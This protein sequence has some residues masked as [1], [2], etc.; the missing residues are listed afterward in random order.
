M[1]KLKSVQSYPGLQHLVSDLKVMKLSWD[2]VMKLSLVWIKTWI[3]NSYALTLGKPQAL[4]FFFYRTIK[5]A[6]PKNKETS[7]GSH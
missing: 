1:L 6:F 7:A 3:G 4:L 5:A 2:Q